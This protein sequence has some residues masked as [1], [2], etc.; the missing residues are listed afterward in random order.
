MYLIFKNSVTKP[1][2]Y[3]YEDKKKVT[4]MNE[5]YEGKKNFIFVLIA[6]MIVALLHKDMFFVCLFFTTKLL[7]L[8]IKDTK[9]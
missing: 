4:K 2:I 9:P 6:Q 8:Y 3:L 1:Y 7:V 5:E